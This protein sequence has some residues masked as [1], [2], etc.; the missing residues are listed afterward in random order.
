MASITNSA[1]NPFGFSVI[2]GTWYPVT[3]GVNHVMVN[4]LIIQIVFVVKM[5]LR[6]LMYVV[7]GNIRI[8][9]ITPSI[10]VIIGD[11]ICIIRILVPNK[12][13]EQTTVKAINSAE[14]CKGFH[15]TQDINFV[16]WFSFV[17]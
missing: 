9:K 16:F 2:F 14:N 5:K 15:K 12:N 4:V 13:A 11:A 17:R 10:N 3:N 8:N 7:L 1:I 6:R